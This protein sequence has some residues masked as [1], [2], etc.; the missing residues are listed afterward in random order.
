MQYALGGVTVVSLLM[1]IAMGIVTWRLVREERQRSAARLVALEAE[2][3][4]RGIVPDGVLVAAPERPNAPPVVRASAPSA[5]EPERPESDQT[6]VTASELFAPHPAP[7]SYPQRRATALGLAAAV[8]AISVSLAI[9]A[10]SGAEGPRAAVTTPVPVELVTL[11][12]AQHDGVLAIS[13]TVRNPLHA[14]DERR[15]SVLA[16]ALDDGGAPVAT[17]RGPV[18]AS[19]LAAGDQTSFSLSIPTDHASRYRIRFLVDDRPVP[20][21]DVRSRP[22]HAPAETES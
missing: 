14:K 6:T 16:I 2:L 8:L 21:L 3:T 18:D 11:T 4:R 13:G 20:H 1:T 22:T 9:F 15:L 7:S 10:G 5:T 19:L 17:G 12:H